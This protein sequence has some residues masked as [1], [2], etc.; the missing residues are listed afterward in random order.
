MKTERHKMPSIKK[1][2]TGF[3]RQL[4]APAPNSGG[5]GRPSSGKGSGPRSPRK[6]DGVKSPKL[7]PDCKAVKE[8]FI[9]KYLIN[10]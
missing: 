4:S 5:Q 9:Q 1:R 6:G 10:G 3:I 8:G 7:G 2:V